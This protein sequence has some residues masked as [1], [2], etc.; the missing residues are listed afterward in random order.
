MT[1]NSNFIKFDNL[2]K[3]SIRFLDPVGS[4]EPL[5]NLFYRKV[6]IKEGIAIQHQTPICPICELLKERENELK[7]KKA[8]D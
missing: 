4:M 7:R 3:I 2:K 1:K 5:D 8:N 6:G